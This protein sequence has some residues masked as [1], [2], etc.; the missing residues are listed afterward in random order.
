MALVQVTLGDFT[1]AGMEV[2]ERIPF[3]GEQSLTVHKFIGGQRVIDAMGPDDMPLEWSGTFMGATALDRARYLDT[4]RALGQPLLLTWDQLRFLVVIQHFEGNYEFPYRIPYRITCVVAQNQ[5]M[6][7]TTVAPASIDDQMDGDMNTANGLGSLI[8]DGP[9]SGLLGGL[10]S[11]ISAVSTF[12]NASQSVI[13]G[14]LQP[15]AAVQTRVQILLASAANTTQNVGTLGGILPN[16]PASQSALNLATQVGAFTRVPSLLSLQSVMGRMTTNLGSGAG[17]S[18][19]LTMAGGNLFSVAAKQYGDA[20]SW[21]GIAKANGLT[22]PVLT[23]VQSLTVPNAP[24][25][26]GGLLGQ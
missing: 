19:T 6:P 17:S 13:D 21:T 24:D 25:T 20:T 1:F 26:A 8:G 7:V 18:T 3:G 11:A 15:I 22:D 14:V 9:L 5:N 16:V 2:P 12:A 10:D 4:Q 23:G